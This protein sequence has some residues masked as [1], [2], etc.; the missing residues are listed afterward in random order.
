M[1]PYRALHRLALSC[2]EL[3]RRASRLR[4]A[5]RVL[6][7]MPQPYRL[8]IGCDRVHLD[9]WLNIDRRNVPGH[10]DMVWDATQRFPMPDAS[11]SLIY[12]EHFLEHLYPEQAMSFL[13]ECHRLLRPGGI[14]RTAMPSLEYLV[15]KYMDPVHWKEQAWLSKPSYQH[16]KTRAEMLNAAFRWWGHRWLYDR[17]ELHRRL[18]DA[19]FEAVCDV[20]R[21][22]SVERDL[23]NRETREDS[24]LLCEALR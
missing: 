15:A 8:H 24:L 4:E 23:C 22:V 3:C 21:G 20:E 10:V 2:L 11:C 13:R 6:A 12:N 9:G 1:N 19:G 17:E 18:Q 16:I 7:R 14:L 5:R